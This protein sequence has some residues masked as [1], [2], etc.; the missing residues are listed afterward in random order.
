MKNSFLCVGSFLLA[1]SVFTSCTDDKDWSGGSKNSDLVF[2]TYLPTEGAK[3]T[4]LSIRGNNFG[5]DISQVQV[6]VNEKEAEVISV[7]ST[8][9][10][11]RV[12]EASGSGVVT[13]S[14]GEVV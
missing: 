13:V 12:A 11:A 2:Q 3:G 5:E 9:I 6:W 8:R 1:A 14:V 10:M 7:T 4:E